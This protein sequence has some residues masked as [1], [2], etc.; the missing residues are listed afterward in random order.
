MRFLFALF[1]ILLTS[2]TVERTTGEGDRQFETEMAKKMTGAVSIH[3]LLPDSAD[4]TNA[5]SVQDF[6]SDKDVLVEKIPWLTSAEIKDIVP[7]ERPVSM[8]D[9]YDLKLVLTDKGRK[10]WDAIIK[11]DNPEN[12]YAFLVDGVFYTAFHPRRFYNKTD[13]EIVVDGPFSQIVSE[14][15]Y[16][17]AP[18][19][20]LKLK[21][22]TEENRKK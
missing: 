22:K 2:C 6:Y 9:I 3:T 15:L 7:A 8:R 4:R 17:Q 10:Q 21:K 5:L 20:Y 11:N 14:L 13:R 1:C 12:G 16:R 18:L 19:N